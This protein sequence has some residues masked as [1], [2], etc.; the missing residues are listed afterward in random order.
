MDL[1]LYAR[2][3]DGIKEV[4]SFPNKELF[5]KYLSEAV[6]RHRAFGNFEDRDK[7]M[8]LFMNG[9]SITASE[10]WIMMCALRNFDE[11]YLCNELYDALDTLAEDALAF[12]LSSE[13]PLVCTILNDYSI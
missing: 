12:S 10:K 7:V 2:F 11:V 1:K 13:C 4:A 3:R 8:A 5:E 6:E 9:I